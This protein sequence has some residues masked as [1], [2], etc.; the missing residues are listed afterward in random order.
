MPGQLK[1]LRFTPLAGVISTQLKAL[2]FTPLA[3]V[4]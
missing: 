3:G 2:R 1:A 4:I